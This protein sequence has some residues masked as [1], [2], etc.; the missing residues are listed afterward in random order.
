[1]PEPILLQDAD[2]TAALGGSI[3]A[4]LRPGDAIAL[5]GNL[6][7]GKTTL[8]RGILRGLG[9]ESE[10]PSPTFAIV[11]PYDTPDTRIP[12]WHVDLYRLEHPDEAEELGL[13]EARRDVAMLIEWPERLGSG[14]W[15]DVLKLHINIE[16]Q[17]EGQPAAR[18]LTATVPPAWESRWPPA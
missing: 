12:V 14:L 10:A 2:A 6:G 18:C 1:M 17:E 9:L 16:P 4:V 13:D 7:A 11:Q 15:N 8:A 5:F 3:A